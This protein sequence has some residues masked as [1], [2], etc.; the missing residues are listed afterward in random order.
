MPVATH[1][2]L[3]PG[4]RIFADQRYM[5]RTLTL[6]D[7]CLIAV[8]KGRKRLQAAERQLSAGPAEGLAIARGTQWDVINAPDGHPCYEALVLA[9][10]DAVVTEFDRAQGSDVAPID[11]AA[12]LAI[13]A[14]LLDAMRRTLPPARGAA[15]SPR[16]LHHRIVEV[17]LLLAERGH[18]FA[19]RQALGWP[20]RVRHLVARRPHADWTVAALAATFHASESTL[21]RRLESSG[22]TLA[23]LAREVR[24]ETAL[25]LRQTTG[26]PVG[27]VAQRCGWQP[28]SRF[29]AAFQQRWG[30]APSAVRAQMKEC[31][32]DMAETG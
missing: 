25:G 12:T 23:A 8:L 14:E 22:T 7:D 18:R 21:R 4:T 9:F 13:D 20:E 5:L 28:H 31:A 10:D 26:L 30:A 11:D 32:Q 27:E 24:L 16:V 6:R 2:P 17:L 3:Q 19:P 15:L 29:T 1:R